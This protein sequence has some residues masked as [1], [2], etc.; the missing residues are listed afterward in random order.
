[1]RNIGRNSRPCFLAKSKVHKRNEVSFQRIAKQMEQASPES[2]YDSDRHG[3]KCCYVLGAF[4]SAANI[5][6]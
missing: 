6:M 1:M 3:P 5:R 4:I 2:E